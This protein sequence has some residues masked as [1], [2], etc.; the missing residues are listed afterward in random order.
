MELIPDTID[1][2]AYME[3]PGFQATVR[4]ASDFAEQ[5]KADLDPNKPTDTAR[6]ACRRHRQRPRHSHHRRRHGD[7]D[8]HGHRP[9]NCRCWCVWDRVD[10]RHHRCCDGVHLGEQ[11]GW[12]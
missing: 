11:I 6:H 12:S 3:E 2:G 7:E 9:P 4:S 8:H 10:H 5:V 1:L